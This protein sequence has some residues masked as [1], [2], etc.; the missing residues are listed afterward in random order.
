MTASKSRQIVVRMPEE[1][2]QALV[3]SSASNERTVAQTVRFIIGGCSW[4]DILPPIRITD[5]KEEK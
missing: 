5:P 4:L 3:E 2:Y 1:M